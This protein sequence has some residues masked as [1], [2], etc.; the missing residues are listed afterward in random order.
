MLFFFTAS[1]MLPF[2]CSNEDYQ[3]CMIM[4][5][6]CHSLLRVMAISVTLLHKPAAL[7]A[8]TSAAEAHVLKLY[9]AVAVYCR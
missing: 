5:D 8:A 2:P 9:A 3:R 1:L 6:C 4:C 7:A